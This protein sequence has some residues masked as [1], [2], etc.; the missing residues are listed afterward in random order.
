M[1]PRR[2]HLL[3]SEVTRAV[4]RTARVQES[5]EARRKKNH[6]AYQQRLRKK[7]APPD[8]PKLDGSY[9]WMSQS[10]AMSSTREL[11]GLVEAMVDKDNCNVL[12]LAK[13]DNAGTTVDTGEKQKVV[14]EG[15]TKCTN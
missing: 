13:A 7:F 1:L 12:A 3:R 14:S 4:R 9:I 8:R 5:Q 15:T 6:A 2:G 10:L 11:D